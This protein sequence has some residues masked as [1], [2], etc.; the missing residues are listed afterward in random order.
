MF[1]FNRTDA[2]IWI[3]NEAISN[4]ANAWAKRADV[5]FQMHVAPIWKNPKNRNDPNHYNWL[6]T[7]TEVPVIYMQEQY[8]EVPASVKF[9][10]DDVRALVGKDNFLSSSV[11]LAIGLAVLQGYKR[12]EVY[13]VA[14]ETNTEYQFQ[15]EG[16]SF[17]YGF[18]L[19]KGI[20]LYFADDTFQ[21][22]IYGYEGEVSMK[23]EKF[24]DKIGE[25]DP[26]LKEMD[27]KYPAAHLALKNAIDSFEND[28]GVIQE[29]AL[30]KAIEQSRTIIFDLGVVDGALHENKRYK[31]KADSMRES[32]G[33]FIFSRQEFEAGARMAADKQNE[34][35]LNMN[36]IGVNLANLQKHMA[37]AA[38]GSKRRTE[39]FK[40][41]RAMFD[42][43]LKACHLVAFY[44][45]AADE[46]MAYM[47][48][49]DKGIRA[50]GG[51][52]SEEVLLK[53]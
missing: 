49:L 21:C 26:K 2:D 35:L 30:H 27:G 9:P 22:P 36:A 40:S 6:K 14:M 5:V 18:A 4:K 52:K 20:D 23:Y 32:A 19:G 41:Y 38:K 31:E 33:E 37:Q 3:F 50:A 16:V 39:L 8:P 25:L 44:K 34:S 43:Y 45:G 15:R 48:Q 11:S 51:E 24:V 46:N 13:G 12:I 17:W 1:D 10:L 47:I 53:Q 7:Q 28:S 42:Q 29:Q